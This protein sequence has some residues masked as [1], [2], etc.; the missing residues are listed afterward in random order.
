[1][2][3]RVCV[4]C[5]KLKAEEKFRKS[6]SGKYRKNT[7]WACNGK[8][9]RTTLK[10]KMFAALGNTCACCGQDHPAFL[11]LDHVNNDGHEYRKQYNEQ[12]MYRIAHREGW[13]KDKYQVLCMSCNFAKGHFGECPHKS[14][15]TAMGW[16]ADMLDIASWKGERFY[17][18]QKQQTK[19]GET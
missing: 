5:G 16:M 19:Q 15:K 3:D 6:A 18:F 9:E 10:L 8:Y 1:M 12:Q 13:P 4:R 11:T 7:C 17:N 14:G 2:A